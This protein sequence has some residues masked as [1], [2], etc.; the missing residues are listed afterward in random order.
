MDKLA[1]LVPEVYYDLIGRIVPGAILCF[2]LYSTFATELSFIKDFDGASKFALVFIVAYAMGLVQ[3]MLAGTFLHWTNQAVFWIFRQFTKKPN[4]W[5]VNVWQVIA[6]ETNDARASK[7]RKMM[8]ERAML[9]NILVL[10]I[11]LWPLGCWPMSIL[12]V[13]A[14]ATIIVILILV[15]YR[16]EFWVRYDAVNGNR[17]PI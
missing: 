16:M 7:L 10:S 5:K 8:A 2:V 11:A 14:N 6:G 17:E 9:R 1:S 12:H 3:D 4:I 15:Y 13:G